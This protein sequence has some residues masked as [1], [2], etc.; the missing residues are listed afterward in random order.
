MSILQA[1]QHLAMALGVCDSAVI[2][3]VL[4]STAALLP[5]DA[6][7]ATPDVLQAGDATQTWTLA[8]PL[9]ALV[10]RVTARPG[11]L[12]AAGEAV[13]SDAFENEDLMRLAVLLFRAALRVRRMRP[14][15]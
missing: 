4:N 5:L 12:A 9:R 10:L 2:Q 15:C 3:S 13:Q 6:A 11:A 8:E 14:H 1:R 7:H